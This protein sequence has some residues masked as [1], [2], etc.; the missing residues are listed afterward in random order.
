MVLIWLKHTADENYHITP[1]GGNP[2]MQLTHWI[3]DVHSLNAYT[4]SD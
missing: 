3:H 2:Q 1:K 4:T